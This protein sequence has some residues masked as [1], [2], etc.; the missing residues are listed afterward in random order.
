M[1]K[2]LGEI[3]GQLKEVN[4]RLITLE[5]GQKEVNT[6]LITLEDGQNEIK[7]EVKEINRKTD[8]IFNQTAGLTEFQTDVNHHL[9]TIKKDISFV[10]HKE[11][12]NEKDVFQIKKQ[13]EI[14]K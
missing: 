2:I 1:E 6:R 8:I 12:E 10:C 7:V 11:V 9:N 5:D 14:I 4:T 3:L 13:L